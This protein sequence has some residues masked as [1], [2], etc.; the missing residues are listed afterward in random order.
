VSGVAPSPEQIDPWIAGRDGTALWL[1]ATGVAVEGR[2]IAILGAPG[3]GKSSL[4]LALLAYGAA[5]IADDGLWLHPDTDPPTLARP[6]RASGLIE[7]RGVG[8]IRAGATQTDVPLALVVDLDHAEPARLP[9]RRLAA[10]GAALCPMIRGAGQ[11]ALAPS[12]LL[13]VRHGRADV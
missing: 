9:P 5:L 3:T 10:I 8:L 7:A 1:N 13:M 12:I 11:P 2:G 4:A 6:D